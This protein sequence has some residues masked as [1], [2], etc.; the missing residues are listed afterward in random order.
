MRKSRSIRIGFFAALSAPLLAALSS[1][2]FAEAQPIA[3]APAASASVAAPASSVPAP[4]AL[5]DPTT[6]P[7]ATS[8][9]G[10]VVSGGLTAQSAS[11]RALTASKTAKVDEAKLRTAAAAVDAAVVNYWPQLT[12]TARYMRL[13]PIT[14][15][16]LG[17]LAVPADQTLTGPLPAG[18]QLV[19]AP[20]SF[21]VLLNQTTFQAS[22]IVPLSDYV[23]RIAKN[24]DA[25]LQS[26]EATKWTKKANQQQTLA[27]ARTA[28]YNVLRARG[29]IVVAKAAVAQGE[30]HLKDIKTQLALKAATLAD[31]AR[32]EAQVA[33]AQFTLSK[34]E[35][36][37][38]VSESNLKILMGANDDE[39]I[40]LGEDLEG[41]VPALTGDLKSYKE[42]AFRNR[43]EL[44][45]IDAQIA[46]LGYTRDV[47]TA[48]MYP[49]LVGLADLVYQNPNQRYFPSSDRFDL[50]WDLGLQLSWSPNDYFAAAPAGKQI[51]ATLAQLKATRE[52]LE[53]ALRLEVINAYSTAKN[54]EASVTAAA[55]QRKAAEQA[56]R[57]R[58]DQFKNGIATSALL[59]DAEADVTV[60]RLNELNARV[61]VRIGRVQ[62][63]K[64][65]GELQ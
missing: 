38:E 9:L 54:A 33:N 57:V 24:H 30:A 43:A 51:D 25:Q 53:D 40:T 3:T 59:I 23:F 17:V 55:A 20:L 14:L 8:M 44:K 36:L 22:L 49:R 46:S 7:V 61:D 32:V 50:T 5:P 42:R 1:A 4:G 58:V 64:A 28:F 60:A 41:E 27:D 2:T 34:A 13:S 52:Q 48:G 6:E 45:S 29:Q 39:S 31:S 63:G 11:T 12:L 47:S 18:T 16:A 65:T 10:A 19:A 21:P 56:Y 26:L 37:L 15:P 35:V 62:L